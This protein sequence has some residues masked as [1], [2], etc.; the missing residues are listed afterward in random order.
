M[1]LLTFSASH[2][3]EM[4]VESDIPGQFDAASTEPVYP[5]V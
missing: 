3:G 1:V 4:P 5:L 2:A